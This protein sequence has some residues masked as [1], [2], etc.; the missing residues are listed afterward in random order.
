MALSQTALDR[1]TLP[2]GNWSRKVHRGI[3]RSWL[4]CCR[5]SKRVSFLKEQRVRSVVDKPIQGT[6]T[7]RP[8]CC[9]STPPELLLINAKDT[10]LIIHPLWLPRS[11]VPYALA[12]PSAR[13]LAKR[14][15]WYRCLTQSPSVY[16]LAPSGQYQDTATSQQH[17]QYLPRYRSQARDQVDHP[18]WHIVLC[19]FREAWDSDREIQHPPEAGGQPMLMLVARG[20]RIVLACTST[21]CAIRYPVL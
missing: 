8:T 16:S 12:S 10:S 15:L 2:W 6:A 1:E 7:P 18:P 13:R 17:V 14:W 19:P 5:H 11:S 20:S 9:A 21:T 3:V 4:A